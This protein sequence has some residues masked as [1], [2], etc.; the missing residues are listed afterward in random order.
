MKFKLLSKKEE[1]IAEKIVDATFTVH[2]VLGSGLLKIL[3]KQMNFEKNFISTT[4]SLNLK[5]PTPI[6]LASTSKQIY[7]IATDIEFFK[8][9]L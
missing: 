4:T 3:L 9:L 7:T 5:L 6:P 1:S 8:V 2:K